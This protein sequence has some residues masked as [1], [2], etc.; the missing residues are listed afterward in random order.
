[1]IPIPAT[2]LLLRAFRPQDL[3]AAYRLDQTCFEPGIAYS[4]AEI[5]SFLSR[6]GAVALVA[7]SEG[8]MAGFAIGDCSGERGRV[9]TID[10][11]GRARRRGVGRRLLTE[12]LR[13]FAKAGAR[14]VRLEVDVRN[15]GAIRFYQEMGFRP[16]RTLP[17]YYGRGLD[18]LEMVRESPGV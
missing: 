18:G 9:V 8:K 12:L 15:E 16:T 3:E 1:M 6:P 14:Q 17:G 4:R 13:W 7:E 10:V 2:D 5:R 11:S